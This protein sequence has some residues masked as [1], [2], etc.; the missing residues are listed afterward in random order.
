MIM[1]SGS[2]IDFS[3]VSG[4]HFFD[5]MIYFTVNEVYTMSQN[6]I[7]VGNLSYSTTGNDLQDAF[8][9]FGSIDDVKLI[10]DRE[11]G[12]SK[13]FA[14]IT[15]SSDDGASAALELNGTTLDGRQIKVSIAKQDRN[16]NGGG[17]GR[18][19]NGGGGRRY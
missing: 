16:R 19:G 13:G 6:K 10:T 17:G 12:R 5:L 8:G 9:G 18:G 1:F 4:L 2:S 3:L 15:F 7:Y 14:F 11:T